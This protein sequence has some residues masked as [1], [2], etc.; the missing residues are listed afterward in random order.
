MYVRHANKV[1]TV[2]D[3]VTPRLIIFNTKAEEGRVLAMRQ[4]LA[5][6]AGVDMGGKWRLVVISTLSP[7][8]V[9]W[10]R[11]HAHTHSSR[12]RPTCDNLA[13]PDSL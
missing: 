8:V 2:F 3:V 6:S 10:H 1:S 4:F 5:E 13:R 12:R 9:T 7:V 11:V